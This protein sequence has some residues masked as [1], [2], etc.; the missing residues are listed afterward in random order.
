MTS[1]AAHDNAV[2]EIPSYTVASVARALDLVDLVAAAPAD[3]ISVTEIAKALGVSKSTA[4]ALARTLV[5]RAVLRAVEPGPRYQ[6]GMALI[7]LGDVATR[8][9]PLGGVVQ[10][11]LLDLSRE[12]GMTTRAALATNGY[13]VFIARIDSPGTV[14]FHTPLGVP[15]LPHTSSAGK[16]ILAT[17]SAADV[18]RVAAECGL[19]RRTR[20]T[21][22]TLE[23]LQADLAITRRRGYAIDDEEDVEGVFCIA[24]A[25]FDHNGQC[26]GAVS[27]TGIKVDLPSRRVE[28][29]AALVQDAARKLSAVFGGRAAGFE[30]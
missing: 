28:E 8:S 5:D 6:P 17:M 19:P 18:A 3:G 12:T 22:A 29:L 26:A 15:E 7:R 30:Y 13:P 16:A 21:I 10:P 11:I 1:S 23:E 9:M 25:F 4:Y 20:K 14:R 24:A 27:A 2:P